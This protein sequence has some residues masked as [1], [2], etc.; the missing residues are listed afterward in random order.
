M[1][2]NSLERYHKSWVHYETGSRHQRIS[3]MNPDTADRL[4]VGILAQL[5]LQLH[6]ACLENQRAIHSLLY[7][8]HQSRPPFFLLSLTFCRLT[9]GTFCFAALHIIPT[10]GELIGVNS[11]ARRRWCSFWFARRP[12]QEVN[13]APIVPQPLRGVLQYVRNHLTCLQNS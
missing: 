11:H 4:S 13:V 5:V 3:P 1:M 6:N 9:N 8:L 7:F 12:K 10:S 2:C